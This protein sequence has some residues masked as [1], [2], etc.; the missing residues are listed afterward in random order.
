MEKTKYQAL[1][2]LFSF[3]WPF[4][5]FIYSIKNWDGKYVKNTIWWFC[6]Y[7]GAVFIYTFGD[8]QRSALRLEQYSNFSFSEIIDVI[9]NKLD[10]YVPL[11]SYFLSKI[12]V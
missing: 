6:I 2:G 11:V 12:T 4:G 9:Y 1:L 7:F 3:L 8:S 5:G 10:G